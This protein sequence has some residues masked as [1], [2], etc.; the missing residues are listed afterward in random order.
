[1]QAGRALRLLALVASFY[2]ARSAQAQPV[3]PIDPQLSHGTLAVSARAAWFASSV[4]RRDWL[5]TISL[6]VPLERFAAPRRAAISEPQASAEPEPNDE[7][8]PLREIE[9]RLT[10]ELARAAVRAALRA[11]GHSASRRR[12]DGLARR[13]NGSALL[14]ELRLRGARTIDES[15]RLAPTTND[16]Y[17]YTQAGGTSV[18]FEARLTWK[19][20]RVVFSD[21]ELHIERLR[22]QRAVAARA[23]ARE[24][25]RALTA[26]QRAKVRAQDPELSGVERLDAALD[27]LEA[28]AALDVMTDGWFSWRLLRLAKSRETR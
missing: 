28:E 10:P 16:P 22:G 13:A 7:Q 26:W 18:T 23:L 21:D 6:V 15:L 8:Q 27:A 5:G 9:I 24:V 17:R 2:G 14:P 12:L 20:N 1:M 19:L 25:L 4:G 3:H 11:S